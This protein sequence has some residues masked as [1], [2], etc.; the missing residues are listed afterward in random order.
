MSTDERLDKVFESAEEISFDHTSKFIL[1]S[2]CHRGDNSWA[3]DFAGN[4][5]L[6]FHALEHYHTS[7]FTYIEVGDG[8]E[9]WE[10]RHFEAIRKAHSD[11]FWLMREFYID[12]RLYLIYGNHDIERQDPQ[13]VRETLFQY[14]DDRTGEVKPLFENI[15]VHEGLMLVHAVTGKRIFLVHG[16]Q[17]D[18]LSDR[19]WRIG[20]FMVRHFWRHLQLV[21][22]KDQTSPAQNYQKR[23]KVEQRLM[24][25]SETRQHV[26]VAGHT[27]RPRLPD[28]GAIPYFNIGSCVHPR[29]ITGIEIENE[30]IALIKWSIKSNES[31]VLSIE[32]DILAGPMEL[33]AL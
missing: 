8:D 6:F 27:H 7:G 20:R 32:R 33:H 2:D 10:N 26:L 30:E 3:D 25:W 28:T 14:Y 22:V 12:N 9:L 31:G 1:F 19:W 29:C 15:K 21:G 5:L 13:K 11:I 24:Q 18:P 17:A 16:H 23:N 4:Q